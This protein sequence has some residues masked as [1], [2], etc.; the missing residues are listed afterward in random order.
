MTTTLPYVCSFLLMLGL[1]L[2]QATAQAPSSTVALY[3]NDAATTGDVFTTAAGSDATG[4]GSTAAPY[5]TIA[6]AL[7]QADSGTQTIFIDAGTYKERI[8]LNKNVNLRGAGTATAQPASATIFEGG[9]QPNPTQT[10]E[11]GLLLTASGGT[12]T[13]PLRIANLTIRAYDFGIQTDGAAR[14]NVLVEDV[15]TIA[16][17]QCGIFWNCL[18]GAQ[19][20][21]FRRVTASRSAEG[22]NT[23]SNG[24]GR[25]LFLVNGHKQNI[26][27]ENGVFEGNRRSGIDVNDGSVSGLVVRG[28][29]FEQNLE[30]ALAVLGAGGQRDANGTFTSSS[31]LIEGNIIR[32]NAAV[33]MELKSCTGNGQRS[34]AGSFVVR[35][36]YIARPLSASAALSIDHAGIV[37]ID[38]DRNVINAGGGRNGDLLTG[39]AY[40]QGNTIRGF[41]ADASSSASFFNGF[42]VV[43]EGISNK[44]FGNVVAQCQIA[45]QVQDRPDNSTGATP[46]FNMSRNGYLPSVGDSVRG[47]RLDSCVTAIRAI[48]LTN[49]VDASLNWLGSSLPATVRGTAGIDGSVV[50]LGG[51]TTNFAPVSSFAPTG[52]IDF[53]PYL[54]TAADA[55][56]ASG[57][58]T[59]YAYLH[60][61]AN[62]PQAGPVP[63]LQEAANLLADNGTLNATDG[64]YK[65]DVM[66]TRSLTLVNTGATSLQNLTLNAP[67]KNLTMAAPFTLT[68]A[69][70]L[71]QG[72]LQT[73]PSALLTVSN[74]ATATE[75]SPS[76]YVEGPIRKQ[77]GQAFVFPLGKGGQWARLSITAPADTTTTFTAEYI[78]ASFTIRTATAPLSEVSQVEHWI[79]EGSA[80]ASPVTVGLYWENAFRSGIDDFSQDLQVARYNGSAWTTVGNSSLGGGLSAGVVASGQP[81]SGSGIFTFGSLSPTINPLSTQ[82][83]SFTAAQPQP[84]TVDLEW[85]MTS[86]GSTAGYAVERSPDASTWQQ[87]ALVASQGI[88]AQPLKYTFQDQ[89]V[90]NMKQAFYRLRQSGASGVRYSEIKTVLLRASILAVA[91]E[92]SNQFALYPNPATDRVTLLLPKATPEPVQITLRDL[93]GRTVLNHTLNKITQLAVPLQLPAFLNAGVYL[94]YLQGTGLPLIPQQLILH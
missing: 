70:T 22:A 57:A 40:I 36:N 74:H 46:F 25:G 52:L 38:R 4:N 89:G 34:G 41:L 27:I 24:A 83:S 1:S 64:L 54:H 79:L 59:M 39:G 28:N 8:I 82:M 30:P 21:T 68:G 33:G 47:N 7:A 55:G 51:P 19:N 86:E 71:I 29:L 14:A 66:V 62:S 84:G 13:Q 6:R 61:E 16:N 5:A 67:G 43:I 53:S 73:S 3:V 81:V 12:S 76:S 2:G 90:A 72:L 10:L 94:L 42:G 17:R 9:L 88:T 31:A 18:G 20:L 37:F 56:A 78:P 75:G 35:N 93:S 65:G 45:V 63:P 48:N 15:E 85:S 49:V 69:L 92:Q 23:N 50:T 87:I 91:K 58:A 44:V 26:V 60:T 77:G 11:V 80:S 32:N